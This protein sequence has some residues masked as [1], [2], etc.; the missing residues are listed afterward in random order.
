MALYKTAKGTTDQKQTFDYMKDNAATNVGE[1]NEGLIED[2]NKVVSDASRKV[3]H[4]SPYVLEA[5][6]KWR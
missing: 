3:I 1:Y 4:Y 2:V 5:V 6:K